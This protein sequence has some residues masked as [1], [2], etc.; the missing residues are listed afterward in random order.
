[1][2]NGKSTTGNMLIREIMKS[3]KEKPKKEL[4]FE[5]KKSI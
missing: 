4:K 2:G 1:M 5:S 3:Q